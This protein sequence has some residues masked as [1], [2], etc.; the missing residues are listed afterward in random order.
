M[1]LVS[2]DTIM[3]RVPQAANVDSE[4][5]EDAI[6]EAQGLADGACKRALESAAYTEYH[7]IGWG[8]SV[9]ALRNSPVTGTTTVTA[10]GVALAADTG[11][12]LDTANGILS[13]L[14]GLPAGPRKLAVAYT[15]GYT[16]ATCP[17]GL[18]RVLLQIVG[19]VLESSGNSGASSEGQDGYSVTYQDLRDGLP[20]G[21]WQLLQPWRQVVIG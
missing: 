19:W 16:E 17:A 18:R 12:L 9:V 7:D 13:S 2:V 20:E 10:G 11:Y 1:A 15:A 4:V 21:L 8:Q 14:V 5:L 3:G 6:A